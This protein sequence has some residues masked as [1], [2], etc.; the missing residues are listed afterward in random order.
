MNDKLI[1]L[2]NDERTNLIIQRNKKYQIVSKQMTEK[3]YDLKLLMIVSILMISHI[4]Y[5]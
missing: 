5:K 4:I 3:K 1:K 2:T